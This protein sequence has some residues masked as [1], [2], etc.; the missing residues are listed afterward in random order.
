MSRA[1]NFSAGPA[2]LPVSVLEQLKASLLEFGT[3]QAGIMEISHRSG[4]FGAVIDAAEARMRRVMGIPDEYSV[5]FLQ[6]GASLQFF[7]TALN[8]ARPTDKIDYICT[9]NW[10]KKAVQEANRV[11]D[12]ANVWSSADTAFDHVPA[13]SDTIE[14]RSGAIAAHYT[15]NNTVA[16][17]QFAE[18]PHT[19]LPLIADLSS[20]ICSRPVDIARHAVLYAGAQ[21][22]LGPSGVT[23]VILSPWAVEQSKA[24]NAARDGG[25]PSMLSY[26]VMVQKGSMFNTP[27][28]FGIFALERVL[29]WVEEQGGVPHFAARSRRR[30]G[31]IYGRLDASDFWQPRARAGS[32]SD[33]NIAWRIHD[34]TLEPTFVAEAKDAG[35]LA[36]KGHRS[37]GGIRASLYNAL[38]DAAVDAL[39]EFLGDFERRHG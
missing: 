16:G 12:A 11:C 35:L 22:N 21:K 2:V 10:S 24:A 7:M 31:K 26:D 23:A 39:V 1:H 28:T 25:I 5:L 18:A 32:R 30:A 20:D 19:D 14:F 17:T 6:G 3:A 13:A 9:G 38:P 8:I 36:L 15:S 4:D 34:P 33:M 27:N 29:A 37:M